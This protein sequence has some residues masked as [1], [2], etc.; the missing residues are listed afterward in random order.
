MPFPLIPLAL[1]IAQAAAPSLIRHL[2][3]DK[4]GEAAEK[5]VQTAIAVTGSDD[6]DAA[7][8]ALRADPA[9]ALELQTA[10]LDYDRALWQEETKRIVAANE[11][12]RAEGQSDKWWVSG[13]R[14][15]WGFT[16]AVTFFVAVL[17]V[18]HVAWQAVGLKD[19][20]AM[21]ML[22]ALVANLTMLFGVPGAILGI[23]SWHRGKE[24]RVRAGER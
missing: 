11:T 15:F 24:K 7:L 8:A 21:A 14:P 23:A 12:M 2:A 10:L 19:A 16:S 13:W 17:G 5:V 20:G 4:A 18:L 3:G 6:G 22:P 1:S 9:K